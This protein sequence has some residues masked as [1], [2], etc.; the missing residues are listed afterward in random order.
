M[1]QTTQSLGFIVNF[2]IIAYWISHQEYFSN[3]TS[4]NK[5]H[6]F[7]E[8]IFLMTIAGMPFNNHFIAA[9]PTEVAPRLAISS[10]IFFAGILT[11]LS[12]SYATRGNRLVNEN[13]MSPELVTFMRRQALIVPVFAVVAAG[14]AVLNPFAWDVILTIGPLFVGEPKPLSFELIL[15]NTVLFDEIINHCLLVAVEP[16][17]QGDY[18]EMER[19]YG[20]CHCTNRLSVILLDNNIIQSI[21]IIAPY[22]VC[23]RLKGARF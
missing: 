17:S 18:Q 8:L 12:W 7:I 15:E 11:F 9:F 6:I 2:L 16:A 19:F 3:Y 22:G 13:E 14:T 21:R 4:T 10:D 23:V 5:T 20:V 1:K